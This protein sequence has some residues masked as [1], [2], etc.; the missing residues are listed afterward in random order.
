MLISTHILANFNIIQGKNPYELCQQYPKIYSQLQETETQISGGTT[1]VV[2]TV[3]K[4][5]LY[6]AN[7]G[8][9]INFIFFN[10]KRDQSIIYQIK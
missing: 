3:L 1:A 10:C 7:V 8:E 9:W 2:A 6:V 5:K 4:N